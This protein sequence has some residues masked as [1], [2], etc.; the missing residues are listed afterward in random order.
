MQLKTKGV[1]RAC[2]FLSRDE[3]KRYKSGY[4]GKDNYNWQLLEFQEILI[5]S[6]AHFVTM[7]EITSRNSC[8]LRKKTA[9]IVSHET[10]RRSLKVGLQETNTPTS[11]AL[12]NHNIKR[13]GKFSKEK[14]IC[15][16]FQF[17]TVKY[18]QQL[19]FL[20]QLSEVELFPL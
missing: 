11:S 18:E 3:E 12:P 20:S 19:Y 9:P 10:T 16:R 15:A 4:S 13:N 17:S 6:H 2:S 14:L 7:K 8:T 5:N 1:I